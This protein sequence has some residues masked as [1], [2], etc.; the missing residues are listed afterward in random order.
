MLKQFA[1][2]V[3]DRLGLYDRHLRRMPADRWTIAMYHRVVD[4][5]A[6]DPFSLGM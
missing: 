4:D 2:P 3:L 1:S 5:S 6:M